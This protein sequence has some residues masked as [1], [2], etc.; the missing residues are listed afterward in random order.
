MGE[1]AA[2]VKKPGGLAVQGEVHD[3]LQFEL[4]FN[5]PLGEAG[6]WRFDV[7]TYFFVPRNV[8]LNRANYTREQFYSDFTAYM[9]VDARPLPLEQLADEANR[10]SPLYQMAEVLRRLRA[11]ERV[12]TRPVQV[13]ARLFA[14]LFVAAMKGELRRW[15]KR[16][17]RRLRSEPVD[18]RARGAS[19]FPRGSDAPPATLDPDGKLE[20]KLDEALARVA[21]ALRRYRE[22][23]AGWWPF[24]RLCHH[25]VP[26]A[27][28]AADEYMSLALEERLAD[29]AHAADAARDGT[30][31]VARVQLRVRALA[32]EESEYRARYGYLVLDGGALA[33]DALPARA[34]RA[35][36]AGEHFTWR[37][38]AL[39]K[40]VQ[41]ALYLDL[42]GSRADTFVRN[43][44]A[45]TGAALAAIWALATQ[46]PTQIAGLPTQTRLVLFSAAVLAYV[47][48]DRIKSL[49]GEYLLR[50]ARVF[51]HSS[52]V[53][54]PTLVEMGLGD[55]HARTA[56]SVRFV[57]RDAVPE[58]VRGRRVDDD[59][60]R[61]GP[62]PEEV[63]H[64]RKRLE[65][66]SQ[67]AKALPEG[68]RIRDILRVN[69][70]HFLLRLDDPK[71]RVT[72]FDVGRGW[73]DVRDLP[74]VYHVH[75]L[76]RV[77]QVGPSGAA[78]EELA[79]LRL[80]LD[81]DG[82]VRA[83]AV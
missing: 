22:V 5:Y 78:A 68:Y 59:P 57:D 51:D 10:A 7:D 50:R 8:G 49:T 74:R 56:E 23:R 36:P 38:S 26:Q 34:G 3:R 44:V 40:N 25:T 58:E 9:R 55:L 28:R 48:K 83:E 4:R 17:H 41:Q 70:R 31:F 53:E 2:R 32:R 77:R 21:Q 54:G 11:S 65:V 35:A 60:R 76:M 72:Y 79:H 24:E 45:A 30:G 75:V 15:E 13:H 37:A 71:D 16:L 63:I 39:K 64:Y 33:E 73:F 80:V 52:V 66:D 27:M 42:R 62:N 82:I 81:K 12:P 47:M 6:R 18:R 67:G 69:V 1:P 14:N 46:V 61:V 19:L 20:A 43:A 29:L